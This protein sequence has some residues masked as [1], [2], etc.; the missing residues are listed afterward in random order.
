M[1]LQPDTKL[2][3]AILIAQVLSVL[4]I[5]VFVIAI[6]VWIFNL[7]RLSLELH[8]VPGASVA[9][10]IV[11]IPVFVILASVLTY[12]YVGLQRKENHNSSSSEEK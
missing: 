4:L 2:H 9:I 8:D 1:S 10:S 5:W 7:I 6:S 3:K 11:A 12:V